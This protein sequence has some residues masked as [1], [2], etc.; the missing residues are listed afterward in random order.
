MI[1]QS[2]EDDSPLSTLSFKPET[3]DLLLNTTPSRSALQATAK[4]AET[5]WFSYVFVG[6]GAAALFWLGFGQL[7]KLMQPLGWGDITLAYAFS[8]F[9][10]NGT[11]NGSNWIGF[12]DGID[13]RYF[14]QADVIQ[15]A[16]AGVVVHLT[17]NTFLGINLV[18][19]LSFPLTALAALWVLRLVGAR[20]PL[21]W[22]LAWVVAFIPF[23][24]GRIDHVY[25]ATMYP[26]VLGVGLAILI[27]SGRLEH[28]LRNDWSIPRKIGATASIAAVVILVGWGGLYYAA[29]TAILCFVALL[30]RS[31][32][33]P[34]FWRSVIP[35]LTVIACIGGLIGLAMLPTLLISVSGGDT[36]GLTTRYPIESVMYAGALALLLLPAPHTG[37]SIFSKIY[38]FSHI[39]QESSTF[40]PTVGQL[41]AAN[42]GTI[43]TSILWVFLL[44]AGTIFL[45]KRFRNTLTQPAPGAHEVHGGLIATLSITAVLFFVPWGVNYLFA[46]YV[47]PSIRAWERLVPVLVTL[48][49]SAS[50][51]AWRRLGLRWDGLV[52]LSI[53]VV[54]AGLI[55]FDSVT[56]WRSMIN[57]QV[58]TSSNLQQNGDG[59]AAQLNAAIPERCGVLQLPFVGFPEEV[60]LGTMGPYD[61]LW[62][63]LTNQ[64]K[65]WSYGAIK[66][67]AAAELAKSLPQVLDED[68]FATLRA[69]G[70][71]AIHVDLHGYSAEEGI[72]VISGLTASLGA[73]IATS[74]DGNWIA[75]RL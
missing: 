34:T 7:S 26:A 45:R 64:E 75:F 66:N 12:P 20:G 15:N 62:P 68:S 16:F 74:I 38:S 14:P 69:A 72:S 51:V 71:C 24:W 22:V 42:Y 36:S 8:T 2:R 27:G 40:I 49:V 10:S 73:P 35:G 70:F 63:A 50:V 5:R 67:T 32:T 46:V 58:A 55:V 18:Y 29:F 30:W 25:L 9:W 28:I 19:A 37:A 52:A 33:S 23:H 59:Y 57:N 65:L 44:V 47:N 48:L 31:L 6:V 61:H 1:L 17:G 60:P 41:A 21:S 54:F 56:P 13:L 39:A 11:P 4:L 53:T 3:G 43:I